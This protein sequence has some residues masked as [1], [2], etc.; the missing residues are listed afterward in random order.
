L[1]RQ[2]PPQQ[3]KVAQLRDALA[4]NGR[5]AIE[6]RD[7]SLGAIAVNL[8]HLNPRAVLDRGYAIVARTDGGIVQDSAQ[9][10]VGDDVALTFARGRADATITK[11]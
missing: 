6:R 8:A 7:R 1:L 5:L 3:R 4:R 10:A 11:K 2:P 9:I